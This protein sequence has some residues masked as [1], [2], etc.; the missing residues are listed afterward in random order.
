[1]NT[2][3]FITK[4]NI[5]HNNTYDY[6]LV[7]YKNI[8]TKVAIVCPVHGVFHQTP[9]DHIYRQAG[10]RKC[11]I[12]SRTITTSEFITK[13]N[14]IHNNY[15]IYPDEYVNSTT[16]IR[17]IC[18]VHGEFF[19]T[20][21]RHI[22]GKNKCPTCSN[23]DKCLDHA[24]FISQAQSVHSGRY[25]YQD[26]YKGINTKLFITC[27]RHG[28]FSQTPADH[29]YHKRGC[30]KCGNNVI[31]TSE[32]ITKSNIIH[33]DVYKYPDAY[34][35]SKT[36]IR[37]ICPIHGDF[38]QTPEKHLL[39][40]G[41][42]QCRPARFSRLAID[43]LENIMKTEHIFIQHAKNK[44]EYHIPTTRYKADGYCS[45]TNTVY[46]FHGDTFHGNPVKFN[47]DSKCN[48]YSDLTANQLYLKT[49]HKE[50]VIKDLGYKLVVI[51]ESDYLAIKKE[52]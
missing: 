24:E 34:T 42:P 19:Q 35:N 26:S 49:L 1:M 11:K 17:I 48:H 5:I 38:F 43:W 15:Y 2:S 29:V 23:N 50:Q 51:W 18:P 37:I 13:A 14:L 3:E 16:K 28:I 22:H 6:S 30:P 46:E 39:G 27:P 36:K 20:P 9:S 33:N 41:C 10:C 4:S 7:V 32:F 8:R 40:N 44:G 45:E 25:L 47:P 31:T 52:K 21:D 12:L